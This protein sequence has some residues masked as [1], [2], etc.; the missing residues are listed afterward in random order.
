[1][2]PVGH[3]CGAMWTDG[4]Q[5]AATFSRMLPMSGE[6]AARPYPTSW[7]FPSRRRSLVPGHFMC[8]KF[9]IKCIIDCEFF[10][11]CGGSYCIVAC[12]A[13]RVV[14]RAQPQPETSAQRL[15][16]NLQRQVSRRGTS[17]CFQFGFVRHFAFGK[18]VKAFAVQL[19]HK[20]KMIVLNRYVHEIL[21]VFVNCVGFS[22]TANFAMGCLD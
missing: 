4:N 10:F 5:L 19:K 13:R 22:P 6:C 21:I 12:A 1:M 7:E 8:T 3:D 9:E 20:S 11:W 17:G 2:H 14:R 16:E 15:V 18:F